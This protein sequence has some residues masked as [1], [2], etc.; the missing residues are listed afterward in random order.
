MYIHV[1]HTL[2]MYKTSKTHAN[3]SIRNNNNKMSSHIQLVVQDSQVPRHNL[4][5]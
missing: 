4:V 1:P 2:Y 3:F 5:L